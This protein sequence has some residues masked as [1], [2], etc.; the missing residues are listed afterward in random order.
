MNEFENTLLKEL[1]E[2]KE[3]EE[4]Y[5]FLKNKPLLG[6]DCVVMSCH[7]ANRYSLF[8]HKKTISREVLSQIVFWLINQKREYV[9]RVT[10]GE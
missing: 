1:N 2:I 7:L 3:L 8:T 6:N 9:D 10:I 4:M 5:D